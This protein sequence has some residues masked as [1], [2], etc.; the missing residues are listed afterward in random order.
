M[1]GRGFGIPLHDRSGRYKASTVR[2]IQALV[3]EHGW[4]I[5]PRFT[6]ALMGLPMD[7]SAIEP[8]ETP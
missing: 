8:S 2:R 7:H 4:R 1:D 6:E 3:A 5:H